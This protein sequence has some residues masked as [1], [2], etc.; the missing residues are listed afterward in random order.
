MEAALG[1]AAKITYE[2]NNSSQKQNLDKQ[3]IELF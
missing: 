3:I 2:W 1:R